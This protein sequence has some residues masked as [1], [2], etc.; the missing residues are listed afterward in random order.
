[1]KN[2]YLIITLTLFISCKQEK[3]V[4]LQKDV[5]D[6]NNLAQNNTG[7]WLLD[8]KPYTGICESY[9]NGIIQSYAEFKDGLINGKMKYFFPNGKVEEEVEWTNGIANGKVKYFY[10]NGQLAEEGQVTNESKEGTWKSYYP[11]GHLKNLENWKNNQMQDSV[12]S[13]F[14]NGNLH[15]KGVFVNGKEDGRWVMYDS[16]SGKI[17]GYL[18]Y[19]NGKAVKAEKK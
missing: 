17:D 2:L 14:E 15:S 8:D 10:E 16:I 18:Y 3:K 5:V 6:C 13:Y 4:T 12:F 11:N 7:T 1:M 19:E 9:E